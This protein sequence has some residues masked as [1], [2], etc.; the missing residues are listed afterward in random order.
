MNDGAVP[1]ISAEKHCRIHMTVYFLSQR[2]QAVCP[3]FWRWVLFYLSIFFTQ[4]ITFLF[5]HKNSSLAL[6]HQSNHLILP[7]RSRFIGVSVLFMCARVWLPVYIWLGHT[8][9]HYIELSKRCWFMQCDVSN[10]TQQFIDD[11]VNTDFSN[12]FLVTHTHTH[13][14]THSLTCWMTRNKWIIIAYM[15]F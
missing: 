4:H 9:T 13:N 15:K 11:D 1:V 6:T 12:D 8:R 7:I 14:H 10:C 5:Q 2:L 3:S